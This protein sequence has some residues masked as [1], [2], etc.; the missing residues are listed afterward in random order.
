VIGPRREALRAILQ[1]GVDRGEL[2][3][4]VPLELVVDFVF[5][6]MWYRLLSRHAPINEELAGEI[7]SAIARMLAPTS[8][9]PTSARVSSTRH[10]PARPS[11][12]A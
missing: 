2:T 12:R 6:V 1:R 8:S 3:A 4:A 10:S 11:G 9:A 5:G 7:T